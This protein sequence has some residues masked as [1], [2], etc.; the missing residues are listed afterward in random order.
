MITIENNIKFLTNHAAWVREVSATLST[1]NQSALSLHL[2]F[3]IAQLKL[4]Q[5]K[6]P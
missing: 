1:V 6:K 4:Q 5:D 3:A 2:D